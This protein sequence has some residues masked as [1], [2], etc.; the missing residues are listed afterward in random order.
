MGSNHVMGVKVINGFTPA[1]GIVHTK[2]MT[3]YGVAFNRPTSRGSDMK[4]FILVGSSIYL[5]WMKRCMAH[6]WLELETLNEL[7]QPISSEDGFKTRADR[8]TAQGELPNINKRRR[9]S[10]EE[11]ENEQKAK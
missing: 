7:C 4:K 1:Q 10:R 8:R 2:D 9:R 11:D 3:V 6:N 5:D